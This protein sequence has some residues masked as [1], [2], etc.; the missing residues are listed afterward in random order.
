MEI[1]LPSAID[2]ELKEVTTICGKKLRVLKEREEYKCSVYFCK[3]CSPNQNVYRQEF[4]ILAKNGFSKD[5][6][7]VCNKKL[8]EGD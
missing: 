5:R 2:I 4:E 3:I 1:K 8:G 7:W 6:F